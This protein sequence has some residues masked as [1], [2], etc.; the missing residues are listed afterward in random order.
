[1]NRERTSTAGLRL[2]AMAFLVT[3][4]CL[5]CTVRA[6]GQTARWVKLPTVRDV[7]GP[8]LVAEIVARLPDTSNMSGE[9]YVG[10]GHYA[11]H[12]INA[13][14][15][16][17]HGRGTNVDNAAYFPGGWAFIA[18]EPTQFTLRDVIS[19]TRTPLPGGSTPVQYWNRQ[20]L[21]IFDE[22]AAYTCG[23]IAG[24]EAGRASTSRTRTSYRFAL[25]LMDHARTVVTLAGER[26][27]PHAAGLAG[28]VQR[29]EGVHRQ[30]ASRM[31]GR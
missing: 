7:S 19:R 9:D 24:I 28:Y 3:A 11:G 27:Y 17:K 25:A 12:G 31:G 4:V 29:V 26:G 23:T 13:H 30:I 21:Y 1:M 14:A 6:C 22:L 16:N 5:F 8:G 10:C 2:A 20:P 18:P 15:R